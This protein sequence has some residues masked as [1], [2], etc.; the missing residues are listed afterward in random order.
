MRHI[1]WKDRSRLIL[2]CIFLFFLPWITG[3]GHTGSDIIYLAE[4]SAEAEA[5]LS[6]AQYGEDRI[7]VEIRG[8][9]C[10]PGVYELP[11]DCRVYEALNLAGGLTEEADIS[12]LNLAWILSDGTCLNV[13]S[14]ETPGLTEADDRVN[15]N[16]ADLTE[17]CSLSGI[18]EA[19]ARAII[20]YRRDHG[21]FSQIS[22]IMNVSGIGEAIYGA[23]KEE[24]RVQ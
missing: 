3:C 1:F 2:P 21:S 24:I 10:Y 16:T 8:C 14:C 18:G 12:S 15:I 20:A 4:D 9:V 7:W 11:E 6:C 17:L 13:P 22:D 19:K 23:L 5:L